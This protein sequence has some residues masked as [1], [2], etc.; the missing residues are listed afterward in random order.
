MALGITT[1]EHGDSTP[2]ESYGMCNTP[3][4]TCYKIIIPAHVICH[5]AIEDEGIS[6]SGDENAPMT[7]MKRRS[8]FK[9]SLIIETP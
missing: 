1:D 9:Y 3:H 4:M 6:R 7:Y 2:P 8:W 5:G